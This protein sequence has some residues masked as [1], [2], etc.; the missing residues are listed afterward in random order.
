MQLMF[1][2]QME[3][4]IRERAAYTWPDL[5]SN[6]GGCIGLMTGASVLSLL[7]VFIYLILLISEHCV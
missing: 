4:H 7:E 6:F 3:R 2:R 5:F 1:L